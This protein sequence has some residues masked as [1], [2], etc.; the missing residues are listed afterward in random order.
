[1]S[2]PTTIREM[3]DAMDGF[4]AAGRDVD[5]SDMPHEAKL[6][7]LTELSKVYGLE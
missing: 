4:V 1:M 7:R 3:L 2:A 5:A 6:A